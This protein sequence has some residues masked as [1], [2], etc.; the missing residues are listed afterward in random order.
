MCTFYICLP[1]YIFIYTIYKIYIYIYT[2][3]KMNL[4]TTIK[5]KIYL[6]LQL[7]NLFKVVLITNKTSMIL[8]SLV[9]VLINMEMKGRGVS[10]SL[11][12]DLSPLLKFPSEN[13]SPDNRYTVSSFSSLVLCC[14]H[15]DHSEVCRKLPVGV[16]CRQPFYLN[17]YVL[18][19]TSHIHH[20]YT[21]HSHTYTH[22][23]HFTQSEKEKEGE[24]TDPNS[25]L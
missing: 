1:K 5:L 23:T 16:Q 22:H 21:H 17:L 10:H 2:F 11:H 13:G 7:I 24:G 4:S 3:N 12:A 19:H 15:G 18:L 8:R 25:G 9:C 20:T 6:Y 14:R